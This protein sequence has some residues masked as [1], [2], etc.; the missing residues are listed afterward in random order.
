MK[1]SSPQWSTVLILQSL[2]RAAFG[3]LLIYASSD[4]LGDP[5][6]FLK[7]IENYHVLPADLLPLSAVVIPWLEFFTGLCLAI[8]FRWRGAAFI[9]CALMGIYTLALAWNLAQGAEM[10]CGCF[11]MDAAEK[12]TGWTVLRDLMFFLGGLF[13]LSANKTYGALGGE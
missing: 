4:K 12:L 9:F 5:D 11:A 13:V 10:N 1:T 8:G 6:K 3:I 7:V 2:L